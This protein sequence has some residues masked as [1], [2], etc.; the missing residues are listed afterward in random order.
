M[1]VRLTMDTMAE[2]FLSNPDA[3]QLLTSAYRAPF[4]VPQKV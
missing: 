3:N 1:G 2:R 4:V